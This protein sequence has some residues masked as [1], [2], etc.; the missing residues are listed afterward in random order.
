MD[1]D[2]TPVLE[3]WRYLLGGLGL[4]PAAFWA[5]TPAELALMLGIEGGGGAMTRDRL[6]ELVARYPDRPAP[7][8]N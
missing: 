1:F 7:K 2:F 5:L 3:S 8:Q 6:A 4:T